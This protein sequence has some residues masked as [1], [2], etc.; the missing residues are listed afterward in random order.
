M[1]CRATA[2]PAPQSPI[3]ADSLNL[4]GSGGTSFTNGAAGGGI[5]GDFGFGGF[6]GGGEG[7]STIGSG[8]GGG[9]FSGGNGG[10]ASGGGAGGTSFDGGTNQQF[11]IAT[12]AGNG[13]VVI[14]NLTPMIGGTVASQTTTGTTT[15]DPFS[16]V[17]ISDA[18][19]NQSEKVLVSFNGANGTLTDPNASSDLSQSNGSSYTVSGS[20]TQVQAD[21]RGLV[22][23]P[24]SG[25]VQAGQ[26]ITTGFTITDSNAFATATDTTTSVIDST[27]AVASTINGTQA[28]QTTTDEKAISPFA[29]VGIADLNSGSPTET[30]TVTPN[31][32]GNGTL[33]DTAGGTVSN[34]VY[35]VSGSASTVT[36]DLDALTFTPNTGTVAPGQKITTGFTLTDINSAGQ[37][38]TASTTV[39]D[40]VQAP[41]ITG[42][43]GGHGV[44]YGTPG[45]TPSS[46]TAPPTPSSARAATT[47][48][49]PAAARR[50]SRSAT[51]TPP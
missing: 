6:G 25:T 39:L 24:S 35:T 19:A 41:T 38:A 50:R 12:A 11:S 51:A 36:T 2:S 31:N 27:P 30:V 29:H 16:K 5:P 18:A 21:L 43:A 37:T 33:S 14:T 45:P 23:T 20:A 32:T 3:R 17:T 9:G 4:G 22:F 13:E 42:P 44:I 8:G 46:P 48:S 47:S 49:T 15:V 40:T 10:T 1:G 26:T 34:G 7:G 28:G